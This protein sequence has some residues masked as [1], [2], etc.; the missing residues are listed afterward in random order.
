MA[1]DASGLEI[2]F[3]NVSQGD[4][5]LIINR[6]IDALKKK[7]IA[8][9]GLTLPTDSLD[10]LPFAVANKVDLEGTVKKALLI[11]GGEDYYGG[12]VLSYVQAYGV[13]GATTR[14]N[15]MTLISHYHSDHADGVRLIYKKISKPAVPAKKG[16]KAKP[17]VL[18]LNYPPATAYDM[19]D[20]KKLDPDTLTYQNYIK[21]VDDAVA[22]LKTTRKTLKPNDTIDFGT[23][24][25]GVAMKFTCVAANGVVSDGV[26]KMKKSIIDPKKVPDQ[27]DRSVV[28]VLEYGDFRCIFGGDAGGNG[29]EEGGNTGA[30]K[31]QRTKQFYSSHGDLEKPLRSAL[32]ALY[33]ADAKRANTAKGHICC[34]KAHHHG[35]GSS[36]DVYTLLTMEP[37]L[38]FFSSGTRV[39]FHGHATQEAINRTDPATTDTWINS[40][41]SEFDNTVANYYITE[42]AKDGKYSWGGSKNQKFARTFAN[43]RI[44]G[45]IIMRPFGAVQPANPNGANT[46]SI[47]VYGTGAQAAVDGDKKLRPINTTTTPPN[48]PVGPWEHVCDKH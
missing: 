37:K 47:Q 14:A 38:V 34:F 6:D 41:K 30:N 32:L 29:R 19:G 28:V 22:K 7:I 25:N 3:I 17:A 45:D 9:G 44:L 8:K 48:Y 42:L 23:D 15:F 20:D 39:K 24:N 21:D 31:D 46:I 35:S 1:K 36:N 40:N 4:S 26:G 10:Y 13:K 18:V 5:I 27:N 16:Q 11:D 43:G 2:H 33:P 12:D